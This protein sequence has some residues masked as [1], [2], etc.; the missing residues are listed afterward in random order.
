MIGYTNIVH[1]LYSLDLTQKNTE[2]LSHE[3]KKT[4]RHR[5]KHQTYRN[6]RSILSFLVVLN[7]LSSTSRTTGWVRRCCTRTCKVCAP[8][9]MN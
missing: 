8:K 9:I 2:D 6:K 3:K 7:Y 1:L 4:T 5:P